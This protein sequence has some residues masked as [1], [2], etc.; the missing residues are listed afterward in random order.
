MKQVRGRAQSELHYSRQADHYSWQVR[1]NHAGD[2]M[3]KHVESSAKLSRWGW[4]RVTFSRSTCPVACHMN[5]SLLHIS[6]F[7][8]CARIAKWAVTSNLCG[9]EIPI[10]TR[11]S[12]CTCVTA[13]CSNDQ[14]K[15][16]T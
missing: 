13:F 7:C 14:K 6:I 1:L 16:F 11:P 12:H 15:K 10:Q 4:R 9:R 3:W 2:Y 5:C 8:F